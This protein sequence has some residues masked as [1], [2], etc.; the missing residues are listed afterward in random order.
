MGFKE[1]TN[2]SYL[3]VPDRYE[4]KKNDSG[5]YCVFD[6][7]YHT[8][9]FEGPLRYVQNKC[10]E[11]NMEIRD[12]IRK[13]EI[14][15]STND[16]DWVDVCKAFCNKI[17]AE[18][19]FVNDSDFGYEDKNGNLVHMYADELED[20]LKNSNIKSQNECNLSESEDG[21]YTTYEVN[22]GWNGYIGVENEYLIGAFSKADAVSEAIDNPGCEAEMD[23]SVD[24][25][26]DNGDGSYDVTIS[27]FGAEETYTV[28]TDSEDDAQ[29]QALEEAKSGF[30]II[31]VDGEEFSY[32]DVNES[33]SPKKLEEDEGS[34]AYNDLCSQITD[35]ERD[36][37]AKL[38][39]LLSRTE[40][41]KT[42]VD[43]QFYF[44]TDAVNAVQG[45]GDGHHLN[46]YMDLDTADILLMVDNNDSVEDALAELFDNYDEESAYSWGDNFLYALSK[47][48]IG[49][50]GFEPNA[51]DLDD[52]NE[53]EELPN[54]EYG[55]DIDK[56]MSRYQ[57]GNDFNR[58]V[59]QDFEQFL[60]HNNIKEPT[61]DDVNDYFTG[62]FYDIETEEDMEDLNK[63]E[64]II[65]RKYNLK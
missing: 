44:S 32:D 50:E 64:E 51:Y 17:G 13:G 25:I 57:A 8:C 58:R 15:E 11:L 38:A 20:Y 5:S 39:E 30:E 62:F 53:S 49:D 52:V 19:L 36:T 43:N 54:P 63:A 4:V 34:N 56:I 65:R 55:D 59:I 9:N 29:N 28:N 45:S 42:L 48:R 14:T 18:L 24:D 22:V 7:K 23:F 2:E 3:E 37:F 1:E 6:T 47:I 10:S 26:T 60:D 21:E 46:K 33:C 40:H 61:E 35:E 41:G 12:K 27:W 16:K 31:S